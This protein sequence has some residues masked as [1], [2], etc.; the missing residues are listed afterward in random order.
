MRILELFSGTHSVGKVATELGY[1]VLSLDMD[2]NADI[3]IDILDWDYKQY[4]V[5]YFDVIW[6]SPPCNTFSHLRR[7]WI[8]RKLKVFGD[9]I[10]TA[11]ML[12]ND[13]MEVGV[14]I[15][16]K[17]EE[18]INYF[19][20]DLYF[21]ENP[22]T[23]KMKDFVTRP[24]YDVDYC[25]YGFDYKKST[26]IWTNKKNFNNLRCSCV[27]K[28]KANIGGRTTQTQT[29][30]TNLK[31]MHSIPPKLIYDLLE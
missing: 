31:T 20:P 5:G 9:V 30:I 28:H 14:P 12:D 26:R 8:G 16:R 27:G 17:T 24:F 22:K 3:N 2:G 10:V 23:G 4:P 19:N 6:A 18:I 11:E 25:A 15:L 1:E 21:M 13:M 29:H 7:T